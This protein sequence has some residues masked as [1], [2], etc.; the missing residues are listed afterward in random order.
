LFGDPTYLARI[1]LSLLAG[2]CLVAVGYWFVLPEVL[3][4]WPGVVTL[5]A[6]TIVGVAWQLYASSASKGIR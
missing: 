3:P 2:A 4:M 5:V 1:W 6:A